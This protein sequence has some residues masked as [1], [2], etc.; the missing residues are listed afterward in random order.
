MAKGGYRKG[1]G[2]KKKDRSE[3]DYFEDAE[4]YLLAVVQ[5]RAI[6]DAVRVQAAKSLIAYQTAKK[7]APV[8]SPP[9]SKLQAKTERDIEKSNLDDFEKRA[10]VIREKFQNKREVKQ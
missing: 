5:G 8:K 7:R 2:R 6:P 3:Q 1:A 9:P 4:S 10:A